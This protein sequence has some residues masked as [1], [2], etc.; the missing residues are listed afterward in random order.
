MA[1][2]WF[3]L[4]VALAVLGVMAAFLLLA[5]AAQGQIS[6]ASSRINRLA[7]DE[8]SAILDLM[9]NLMP[10]DTFDKRMEQVREQMLDQVRDAAARQNR[11]LPADA[12]Q[13]MQRA[14]KI[15]ISYDEIVY[16]TADAYVKHFTADEIRQIADFY[17][18]SVGKKLARLQPEIMADIMPKISDTINDRVRK[19]M[20]REGLAITNVS[21]R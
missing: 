19:A 9:T 3:H 18:T 20:Q 13:R 16:L 10:Q 15:A 6:E 21:N 1:R 8:R 12:S 2:K 11:P 5:A 17:Q 4:H 7:P 14:M